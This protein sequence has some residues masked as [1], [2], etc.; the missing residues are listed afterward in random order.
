M[1]N[2]DPIKRH[3]A[4]L[5]YQ[6]SKKGKETQRKYCETHRDKINQWNRDNQKR[7]RNKILDK[8]GRK[9]NNPDCPIPREKLD[10]RSLQLDHIH[11]NGW[12]ERKE[13][14]SSTV[15]YYRALK[16]PGDYQLL[17]PYC[18]WMKRKVCLK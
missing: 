15:I 9:C 7:L 17:C 4:I 6:R 16:Y 12:Q 14:G 1:P 13:L 2:K 10:I 5:R 8:F 11:D 3:E 18:N